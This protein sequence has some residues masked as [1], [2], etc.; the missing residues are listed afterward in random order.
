MRRVGLGWLGR[1]AGALAVYREVA[2][3]R[4]QVLG[5]SHPD[6]LTSRNDEARCLAQ[7]GR[8]AEAQAIYRRV[9]DL[10]EEAPESL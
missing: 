2:E 8:T 7:L 6:T 3:G 9:V 10:R 5:A 4:E 1:W